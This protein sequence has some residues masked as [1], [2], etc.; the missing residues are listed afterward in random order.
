MAKRSSSYDWGL[1][2]WS[3]VATCLGVFF[4]FDAGYARSIQANH[5]PI[6]REFRAQLI[7]FFLSVFIYYL[8]STI[9]PNFWKKYAKP[10][11]WLCFMTLILVEIPGLGVEMN[12]A[13]RWLGFGPFSIQPA[14]FM[15]VAVI[16]FLAAVFWNRPQ[17]TPYKKMTKNWG[18]WMDK[19]FVPKMKRIWPAVWVL[20][21]VYI[22]ERE[23]DLGT[24]A[25]IIATSFAM[26]FLG[27]ISKKSILTISILGLLGVGFLV[28]LEPYRIERIL[29]HGARWTP[30]Q[31]DDMG[32]QTTQSETAMAGGGLVGVG[33]GSGRAK[34]MLPAAT[35]DFIMA[36][37]GEEFGLIGALAILAI[38]GWITVRIIR[39]AMSIGDRFA[40]LFLYGTA[41]W[42]GIQTCVNMMMVNGTLPAIG[43]PL[44][45]I[46]SGGSSLLAL[47][48]ALGICQSFIS[49]KIKLEGK[50]NEIS[51]NRR[52]DRRA[53]ISSSS[54]R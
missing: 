33:I 11:F 54:G 37:I 34:H 18:E 9:R 16:L 41:A 14:E 47:W 17:F 21:A 44:P 51:D 7:F 19:K 39:Q 43:I 12:G 30:E 15:K 23:P 13:K 50:V 48:A 5:G 2:I 38:I 24:A 28:T 22:I 26:M 27:G 10:C 31:L 1:F 45:F 3:L 46:S 8:T 29:S 40:Q 49:N 4:I 6:P 20:I 42:I 36:T 25:V 52:R 35:T 53:Y 32:Y